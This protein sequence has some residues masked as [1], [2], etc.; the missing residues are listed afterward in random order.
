MSSRAPLPFPL[1]ILP[2][3]RCVPSILPL[4]VVSTLLFFFALDNSQQELRNTK[5]HV[6]CPLP[7]QALSLS[8]RY[9]E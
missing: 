1:V 5:G 4:S 6:S 8:Q 3:F 2:R 9:L 7:V